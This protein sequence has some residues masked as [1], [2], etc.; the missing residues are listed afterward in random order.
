MNESLSAT[1]LHDAL[2][3]SKEII[4]RISQRGLLCVY[5]TF[6]NEL[7][8]LNEA[9]VGMVSIVDPENPQLRTFK[10]IRRASDGLAY[11]VAIA[12]KHRLTYVC[13][14]ERIDS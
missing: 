6:L 7:A 14:K 13:V 1:T 3:L 11:A 5:V 2:F 12:R 10:V 8:S 9:T 4:E